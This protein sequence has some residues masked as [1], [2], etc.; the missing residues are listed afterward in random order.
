MRPPSLSSGSSFCVRKYVPLKW[1]LKSMSNC[2]SVVSS[3]LACRPTPALFTRK[4][5]RSRCHVAASAAFT[6]S[7]KAAKVLLSPTSSGSA[8]ARRPFASISDTTARALASFDT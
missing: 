5:K 6:A 2:A 1:M 4:S 8:T 7:A 3:K